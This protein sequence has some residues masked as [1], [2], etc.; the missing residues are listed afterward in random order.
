MDQYDNKDTSREPLVYEHTSDDD[1]GS[2]KDTIDQ[3]SGNL[4]TVSDK[5]EANKH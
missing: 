5:N 1:I 2:M 4:V 3:D